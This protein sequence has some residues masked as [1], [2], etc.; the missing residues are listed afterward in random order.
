[1]ELASLAARL[2]VEASCEPLDA[3][4]VLGT[5]VEGARRL[6]GAHGAGVHYAPPGGAA[7]ETEGTSG[8]LRALTAD[9]AGWNEGPGH[10]AHTAGCSLTDL[11]VTGRPAHVRWPRWVPRARALG[12]GRI[13]ALPLSGPGGPVG[14]LLLLGGPGHVL[15]ERALTLVRT[16]TQLTADALFLLREVQQSRVVVA[17]LQ[18]ALTSRVVIEQAKG[19]LSA[20]HDV[21]VDEAFARLRTYARSH[22]RK[23]ADI[24]RE[25]T[26]G[27]AELP[28]P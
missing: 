17:Q 26:E 21:P 14:A 23:I 4:R 24:A 3:K 15:D 2:T 22:Q 9:A 27:R 20:R 19:M 7:V 18:H 8:G 25:I 13:T 11:D 10:E 5:F 16:L 12:V 28:A 6:A 1:M